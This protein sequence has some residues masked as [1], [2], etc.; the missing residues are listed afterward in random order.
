MVEKAQDI[1]ID[2]I[3]DKL[4]AVRGCKPGKQ[5]NLTESEIKGILNKAR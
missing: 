1:D 2:Q 3:I 5:V 4:L